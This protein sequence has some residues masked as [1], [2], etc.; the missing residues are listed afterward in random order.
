MVKYVWLGVGENITLFMAGSRQE[1]LGAVNG[2]AQKESRLNIYKKKAES[3]F[4]VERFNLIG[5]AGIFEKENGKSSSICRA[6]ESKLST[7]G[8]ADKIKK[9]WSKEKAQDVIIPKKKLV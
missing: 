1:W 6:C 2:N 9:E 8:K 5:V 3:S 7:V 4:P